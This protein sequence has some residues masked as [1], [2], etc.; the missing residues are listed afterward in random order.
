MVPPISIRL[1]LVV[2]TTATVGPTTGVETNSPAIQRSGMILTG[3]GYGDNW[4]DP[5][6]NASRD[7]EWPGIFVEAHSTPDKCPDSPT[8]NVDDEGCS[9]SERDTDQDGVNDL[10]DNCPEQPKG[11]DGYDDGCPLPVSE[12]DDGETMILGMTLPVFGGVLA[13]GIVGLLLLDDCYWTTS[14]PWL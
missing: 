13:G 2:K 5:T 1:R 11:P 4:G 7:S 12:T 8:T 6:W 9:K 3:D 10:L 14:K